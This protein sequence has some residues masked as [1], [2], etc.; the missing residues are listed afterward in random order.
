MN[1]A[2]A[3]SIPLHSIF[4]L[5]YQLHSNSMSQSFL[6]YLILHYFILFRIFFNFIKDAKQLSK[7]CYCFSFVLAFSIF[8][9]VLWFCIMQHFYNTCLHLLIFPLLFILGQGYTIRY[10][11]L[12]NPGCLP[13]NW[14]SDFSLAHLIKGC[15][16]P[17]LRL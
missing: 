6:F 10:S 3:F 5:F 15:S 17:P 13:L 2:A 14:V 8:S 1:L 11:S 4:P 16:W 9:V 12:Y 7:V